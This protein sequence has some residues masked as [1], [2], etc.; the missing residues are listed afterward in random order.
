MFD[1]KKYMDK[2]DQLSD[3]LEKQLKKY[4]KKI[5][6]LHGSRDYFQ[7][8]QDSFTFEIIPI[9]EVKNSKDAINITDV[10][11]LHALFVKS[12][13]KKNKKI[14]DEI[15]LMKQFCKSNKI[16]GAESYI[17]GFSGYMCELLIIYYGGFFNLIKAASKWGDKEVID[18]KNFYKG[19]N[20]LMEMNKS[21][22]YSPMIL[23]DPVQADRN[24]SAA[25]STEKYS[26][27]IEKAKE[28]LRKPSVNF[29]ED[30]KFDIDKIKKEF[31]LVEA[32]VLDGKEDIVGAKTLKVFDFLRNNIA[33]KG[34]EIKQD[35]WY[36]DKGPKAYF[37]FKIIR[38]LDNIEIV[39]GPPVK[40]NDFVSNFK[41]KHK[42]TFVKDDMIC[43][44][45]KRKF[46]KAKDLIKDLLKDEYVKER[47]KANKLV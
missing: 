2:S 5:I 34:F 26:L 37:Y 39:E 22:T 32:D 45:E 19:K 28:F 38:D 40:L 41:K 42:N 11:P 8:K 4:F 27:F 18:I 31:I 23:I 25:L 21:K 16:Y 29:F 43:A 15:R 13:V 12:A 36:W 24:A 10:S 14:S 9:L 44:K 17:N 7:V 3:V 35:G 46:T 33:K 47:L 30:Y 6:R 1:Y 20:V